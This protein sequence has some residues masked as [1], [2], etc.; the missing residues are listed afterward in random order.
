[1][2]KRVLLSA[3]FHLAL[4]HGAR[5]ADAFIPSYSTVFGGTITA[6]STFQ[7][8]QGATGNR[9]G[10]FIQDQSATDDMWVFFGPCASAT[11]AT[12]VL[13]QPLNGVSCSANGVLLLDAVCITGTSSDAYDAYFQ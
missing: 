4:M 8:V 13:L 9:K 10:C 7:L 3:L 2:I 1:M 5:A 12:S 6:T 11:K